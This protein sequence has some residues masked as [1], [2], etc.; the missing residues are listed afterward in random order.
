VKFCY[1]KDRHSQSVS[2]GNPDNCFIIIILNLSYLNMFCH[3]FL[4]LFV[5]RQKEKENPDGKR[6]R[7]TRE[8][9][10][11]ASGL[12]PEPLISPRVT[13]PSPLGEVR[14]S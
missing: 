2:F 14:I 12:C 3:H 6:K 9:N 11:K 1:K 7:K 13:Y 5:A 4:S 8:Q 10:A